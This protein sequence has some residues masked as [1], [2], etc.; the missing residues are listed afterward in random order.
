LLIM[1][2]SALISAMTAKGHTPETAQAAIA[3]RGYSDLAR[4][5]L[6]NSGS[7]GGSSVPELNY[8]PTKSPLSDISG[9]LNQLLGGYTKAINDQTSTVGLIDKYNTTF[10]VPQLMSSF[11][12][13]QDTLDTLGAQIRGVPT[14]VKQGSQ[15][16]IMTQG[17]LDRTTQARQAPMIENY[18]VISGNVAKMGERLTQAQKLAETY[19]GAEQAD[20]AKKLM[21]WTQA[22]SNA[23]LLAGMA[24]TE[25]STNSANELNVLLTKYQTG[26][27]ISE[28][29]KGRMHDLAMQENQFANTMAQLKE[30]ANNPVAVG[31]GTSIV[32]P[33]TGEVI[34]KAPKTY[35]P[36]ADSGLT[37]FLTNFLKS[38][39]SSNSSSISDNAPMKSSP[40][41]TIEGNW[42]ST[43][44]SWIPLV[45]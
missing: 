17:Q 7:S 19:V 44:N 28:A 29:E 12:A 2:T 13:G 4:E 43:G 14:S 26:V 34:F 30:T 27:Q 11:N 18:G 1:D 16:S 37:T 32:N 21:P 5:Y 23:Q 3:G 9:Q 31:E 39:K 22:F 36:S 24:M 40:A 8:T 15:E 25:W 45:K 33:S 10:G 41:G 42:Y 20:Q 38:Q 35:A 6:G